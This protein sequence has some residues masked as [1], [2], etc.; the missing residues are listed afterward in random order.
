MAFVLLSKHHPF[1]HSY[2]LPEEES[3][4]L[5]FDSTPDG[6]RKACQW[7]SKHRKTVRKVYRL[8]IPCTSD[9]KTSTL[10]DYELLPAPR[11]PFVGR[12]D[13]WPDDT[14]FAI[15]PILLDVE[16]GNPNMRWPVPSQGRFSDL[17]GCGYCSERALY[18]PNIYTGLTRIQYEF[19][20]QAGDNVEMHVDELCAR[21]AARFM[22]VDDTVIMEQVTA[23]ARG[24]QP[25]IRVRPALPSRAG[26][27]TI[28]YKNYAHPLL[29]L[30]LLNGP[31]P[32]AKR[33]VFSKLYDMIVEGMVNVPWPLEPPTCAPHAFIT[34]HGAVYSYATVTPSTGLVTLPY[35]MPLGEATLALKS[36][37]EM[38][39]EQ[40]W[41]HLLVPDPADR[42]KVIPLQT[43]IQPK[44]VFYH[45]PHELITFST[46][47]EFVYRWKEVKLD[48]MV[49][50]EIDQA[51]QNA[52]IEK[53]RT[54][55]RQIYNETKFEREDG[56]IVRMYFDDSIEEKRARFE[57]NQGEEF[58]DHL[59]H[60]PLYKMG[61]EY[62]DW[63]D[64]VK[65]H[66]PRD[67]W[68]NELKQQ[69]GEYD[70]PSHIGND[71]I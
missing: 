6:Y 63:E 22:G 24:N 43:T 55:L 49:Q 51:H 17:Y 61:R 32:M 19:L 46:L 41:Q 3:K 30:Y 5:V 53:E 13:A 44:F 65:I 38:C 71:S 45:T 58:A 37:P 12:V 9:G 23:L 69:A 42:S 67:R 47:A 64:V 70:H 15:Q 50:L 39:V 20:S 7:I 48:A 10:A 34:T 26:V 57:M 4:C 59:L 68:A 56:N 11:P 18:Y 66:S 35:G 36:M 8:V 33:V 40:S 54:V 52:C 16:E 29:P 21:T 60:L 28:L 2:H 62:M 25:W 14:V 31:Y 1:L 27:V